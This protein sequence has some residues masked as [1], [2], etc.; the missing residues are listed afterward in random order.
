MASPPERFKLDEKSQHNRDQEQPQ[1]LDRRPEGRLPGV[2]RR[3]GAT[4]RATGARRRTRGRR[5]RWAIVAAG[6]RR[7][8]SAAPDRSARGSFQRLSAA[9]RCVGRRIAHQRA[10]GRAVK[11]WDASAIVPLLVAEKTTKRLQALAQRD[12]DIPPGLRRADTER[13]PGRIGT[14]SRLFQHKGRNISPVGCSCSID[15]HLYLLWRLH[16]LPLHAQN[17]VTG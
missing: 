16:L 14:V 15:R 17:D 13:Y 11:F 7:R 3:S 10:A 12:P 6:P 4:G 8:A 1:R 9:R 2:D 5:P